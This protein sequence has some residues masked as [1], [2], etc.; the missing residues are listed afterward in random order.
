MSAPSLRIGQ[1]AE[2]AQGQVLAR[3]QVG[4]EQENRIQGPGLMSV[5]VAAGKTGRSAG[6]GGSE[7][8]TP[9]RGAG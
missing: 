5:G 1:A 8:Q 2:G 7:A 3:E 4:S 6:A 9:V